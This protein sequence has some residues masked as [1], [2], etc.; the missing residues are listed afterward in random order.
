MVASSTFQA[1]WFEAIRY[2]HDNAAS[3][4][5]GTDVIATMARYLQIEQSHYENARKETA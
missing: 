5:E 2:F 3:N 1:A 4:F